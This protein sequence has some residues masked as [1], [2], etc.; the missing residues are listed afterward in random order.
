MKRTT[1]IFDN[2][3]SEVNPLYTV[4]STYK[5][6]V[7]FR[8]ILGATRF[9]VSCARF[10]YRL[11]NFCG[12]EDTRIVNRKGVRYELDLQEGIDL[13]IFLAGSFQKHVIKAAKER[14]DIQAELT[15][16]DVGANIGAIS[17][18]LASVFPESTILAVEPT[19]FAVS[20][21]RRNLLLNPSITSRVKVFQAYVS[22]RIED[23][24]PRSIYSSWSL[25]PCEGEQRHP[26]HLGVAKHCT[27]P[28]ITIDHIVRNE[29]L[30]RLDLVKIDTDGH[31]LEV[32]SGA[33]NALKT[34]RPIV[35]FELALH[36]L[37]SRGQ[38]FSEFMAFFEQLNYLLFDAVSGNRIDRGNVE[39]I[40]PLKGGID[41]VALPT[42]P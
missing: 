33:L 19:E 42:D 27:V 29:N 13:H 40:V 41:V 3:G 24:M 20:K 25:V 28:T 31:E 21:F 18:Q 32:L 37:Q 11:L 36:E 15:F 16:I 5:G 7:R 10:L 35:I 26:V 39:A 2:S 12:F 8:D 34:F 4:S 1:P 6:S 22:D 9:R 38:C 30:S 17:L 14:L 23:E